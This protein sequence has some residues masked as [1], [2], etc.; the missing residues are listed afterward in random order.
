MIVSIK[1]ISPE[2]KQ[3]SLISMLLALCIGSMM[4]LNLDTFLPIFCEE[5]DW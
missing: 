2:V 1:E 3:K 5:H 4:L